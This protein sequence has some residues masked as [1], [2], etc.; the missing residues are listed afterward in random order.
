MGGSGKELT[1]LCDEA[2]FP[3]H[4]TNAILNLDIRS[5]ASM[6]TSVTKGKKFTKAPKF[7]L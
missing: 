3:N 5:Y 6:D 1:E 2:M 4:E 7:S